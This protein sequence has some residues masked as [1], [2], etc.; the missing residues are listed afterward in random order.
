MCNFLD[1][2][3]PASDYPIGWSTADD[4]ARLVEINTR[5]YNQCT[6]NTIKKKEAFDMNGYTCP[7]C[8]SENAVSAFLEWERGHQTL[9]YTTTE[10]VG[11]EVEKIYNK[12]DLFPRETN[13]TPIYGQVQHTRTE[14]TPLA[15]RISPPPKPQKPVMS[16]DTGCLFKLVSSLGIAG[17]T[18]AIAVML[19][20][21]TFKFL[22][23]TLDITL[24]LVGIE[25]M[26]ALCIGFPLKKMLENKYFEKNGRHDEYNEKLKEYDAAL[27]QYE[28]DYAHWKKL[29]VCQR[30]GTAFYVE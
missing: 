8:G 23:L 16:R 4:A 6:Y 9:T 2:V 28:K 19:I 17:I 24:I 12:G 5:R 27:K 29:Y 22:T 30:C 18:S 10:I 26:I 3:A 7:N 21:A 1:F 25:I 14:L 15:K 11:H 13:R 20:F